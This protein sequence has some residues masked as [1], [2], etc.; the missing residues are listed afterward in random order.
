M[1]AMGVK[2]GKVSLHLKGKSLELWEKIYS[3]GIVGLHA[4]VIKLMSY[5]YL[6]G[7]FKLNKWVNY[8]KQSTYN[9]G[10]LTKIILFESI[11]NYAGLFYIAFL[12]VS[13]NLY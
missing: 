1:T 3:V 12:K 6:W 2:F 7:V 8:D 9:A 13:N 11:N 10:L 5:F 4:L